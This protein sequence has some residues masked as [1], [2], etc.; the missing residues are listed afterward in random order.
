[1]FFDVIVDQ[2]Y[3]GSGTRFTETGRECGEEKVKRK[4]L[5]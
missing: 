2:R 4:V 1:M 5:S 3:E